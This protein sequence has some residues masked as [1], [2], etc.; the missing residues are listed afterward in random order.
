MGAVLSA[1]LASQS[2][3]SASCSVMRAFSSGFSMATTRSTALPLTVG[4]N[5]VRRKVGQLVISRSHTVG[6]ASK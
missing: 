2:C 5:R 1:I 4:V 3:F 6:S